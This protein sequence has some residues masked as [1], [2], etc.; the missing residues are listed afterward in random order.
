VNEAQEM[1]CVAM[2]AGDVIMFSVAYVSGFIG[3]R[4][5]RNVSCDACKACLISEIPSTTDVYVGFKQ[6]SSTV[7]S[8]TYPTEKMVETVGTGHYFRGYDVGGGSLRYSQ[9]LYYKY[10]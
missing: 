1:V 3:M 2:C 6:C 10:H 9:V 7:H 5:L 4:L 8:V